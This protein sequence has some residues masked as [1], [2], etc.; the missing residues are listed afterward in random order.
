MASTPSYVLPDMGAAFSNLLV[1]EIR[2]YAEERGVSFQLCFNEAME[3]YISGP[4]AEW[5]K[6]TQRRGRKQTRASRNQ[7]S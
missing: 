1:D 7:K 5:D 4:I 6:R 3:N 2:D